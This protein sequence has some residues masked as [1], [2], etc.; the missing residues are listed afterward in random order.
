MVRAS[1]SGYTLSKDD[2][3]LVLSMEA[4]GDR[5]HD[6]AAWFGVNQGRVAE[7]KNGEYGTVEAAPVHELPPAGPPGIKGRR[8]LAAVEKAI[9]ELSSA[10]D[11]SAQSAA[12]VLQDAVKTFNQNE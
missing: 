2:V 1:R 11:G 9:T 5:S 7:A 8:L 10:S 4:R 6:V 3:R 12:K